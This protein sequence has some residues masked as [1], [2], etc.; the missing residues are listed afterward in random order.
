LEDSLVYKV[1]SR[2]SRATQRN[3]VS[4]PRRFN[5]AKIVYILLD[6][7]APHANPGITRRVKCTKQAFQDIQGY[8]EKPCPPPPRR[9]NVAKI[10]YILLD[11][12]TPHANPGITR[13]VKCTKQATERKIPQ[14]R[15]LRM[16]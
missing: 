1:N 9:F 4:P 5:V 8:T 14:P 2:T 11:H 12:P 16:S 7:P 10:V 3:L 6:H 13:R 15:N